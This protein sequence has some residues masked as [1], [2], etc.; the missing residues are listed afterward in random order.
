MLRPNVARNPPVLRFLPLLL[1][2]W[3]LAEIALFIVVGRSIGVLPTLALIILAAVVGGLVLRQQGLGVLNRMR[4]NVTTGTLP[5][6]TLFDG[7][8]LALA[9]IFLLVPGFLGDIIAIP[10]LLPPVRAW[11]Y[12]CLTRHIR[13]VETTT[14]YRSGSDTGPA[15]LDG[16]GVVD[17]DDEDWKRR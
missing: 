4:A 1:L 15:R 3:P 5:G 7:M 17:L 2:A 12:R 8:A 14:T 11:L 9:A 6:Q 13:V 10:L 16:P